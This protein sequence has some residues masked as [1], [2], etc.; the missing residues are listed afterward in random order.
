[1]DDVVAFGRAE[2]ISREE[3]L[4]FTRR[5]DWIGLIYLSVHLGTIA[6]T[7]YLV[8]LSLETVWVT[9]AMFC[10]G[11]II[12]FLYGPMHECSHRT[13]F[14][15]RWLNETVFWFCSLVYI[16]TPLW[17]RYK[18]ANH[19]IY[20]QIKGKDTEM[21]LP[22]PAT[23]GQYVLQCAAINFWRRN[24][25]ALFR[26]AGGNILH[27]DS[28]FFPKEKLA[29]NYF[30]ARI[31]LVIYTVI[32]IAAFAAQSWAPLV[33]WLIP[34]VLAEPVM[35]S[36]RVVEHTGCEEGPD[37]RQNTRTTRMNSLITFFFWNMPYH[38]EHHICPSVPFH[39]LPAF[40]KKVGH[41]L[42]QAPGIFSV[43]WDVLQHHLRSASKPTVA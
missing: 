41:H 40:H 37:L 38:A 8:Q 32:A 33:Y 7:G 6:V 29:R 30:E 28:E 5:N 24:L 13:A 15:S 20:T 4:P 42:Q 22:S 12:T 1:M 27:S 2:V 21:V 36:I 34:R 19:H 10:H 18:H 26:H 11:I 16:S 35:R 25:G 17:Y 3:L 14:R 43:H 39:K 31:N 9:P 23:I